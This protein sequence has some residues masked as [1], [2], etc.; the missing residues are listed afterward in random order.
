[1]TPDILAACTGSSLAHAALY[2][3][4]ATYAMSEYGIDSPKR[5]AAFLAQCGHET[6]GLQ[7]MHELW[8][9]TED[10]LGYEGRKDLGNTQP[11]DGQRF[12]GRG[13]IM[14]T[15]RA[16]Y[17]DVG[18]ALCIDCVNRPDLLEA[19]EF[20]PLVGAWW[21]KTRGLNELADAGNFT[22]I[23]RVINGGT[24]GLADRLTRWAKAKQTLGVT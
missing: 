4:S 11:G 21:W 2:G 22:Q 7:W 12:M 20:A 3:D 19:P 18:G 5:M 16:N 15:G 13:W 6:G 14:V 1:M 10:Q 9:P 17:T 23:T 24:N 8:G